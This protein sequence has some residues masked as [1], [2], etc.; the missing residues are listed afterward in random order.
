MATA[1]GIAFLLVYVL[2]A[3]AYGS[4][5]VLS[6]R[7]ASPVW[8]PHRQHGPTIRPRLDLASTA[9]FLWS[10][11]WFVVLAF[12]QFD[13]FLSGPRR[14]VLD[15]AQLVL[16]FGF[17]PLIVH[18]MY[19]EAHVPEWTGRAR[20]WGHGVLIG[21]YLAT[22]LA[23][24]AALALAFGFV[25]VPGAGGWI[26][27]TLAALFTTAGVYSA[28]VMNRNPRA[29][30]TH[31]HRQMR[32]V[33]N[34]LFA[35]L[36]GLNLVLVF[37]GSATP[38]FALIN[39]IMSVTPLLFLS[40]TTYYENRFEFYDLVVKRGALLIA[41]LLVLGAAFALL[42]P[43]LDGLP[44]GP[45][46][47]W[48]YALTLVP[49][50]L[51]TPWLAA[52]LGER[53]DRAWFGRHYTPVSAVTAVLAAIQGAADEPSLL[54]AA[55]AS[56]T[57][58]LGVTVRLTTTPPPP[59]P[60]T[61]VAFEVEGTPADPSMWVSVPAVQ[62][63]RVLLSEDL[64]LLRSL[65]SVVT[66]LLENVRLQQRRQEQDLLAHELRVQS[67]QSELKALR[68]QINPH[69]LFNALN[70]V[71]S[72]I[73]SD[74]ARADRAVEQLSEVFRHTLRRSESEWAPLDQELA[75]AAA[76]LDVEEARFGSRLRYAIEAAPE[77][78]RALVPAMLVHTLVENAVKHGIAQVRGH[79]TL[80]VVARVQ[81][82]RLVVEVADNGPG[83]GA[84]PDRPAQPR[85]V[86]EQF[87]LRSVRDRLRGHF[88]EAAAFTLTRDDARG[89]TVARM[90][91][92]LV[93]PDP[94]RAAAGREVPA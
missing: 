47:P 1:A 2:G 77:A 93:A 17:P 51:I 55:E 15:L 48:L 16:V 44:S 42:L 11:I 69:F 34:G 54:A 32:R 88:G 28:V 70:T 94:K 86:G 84:H 35:V 61:R 76:Y 38:S 90:E 80:D 21:M 89:L 41:A 46:R 71:A 73:H 23:A 79:G 81:G 50:L 9:M 63:E 58:V 92:P 68:A 75:F 66:Y 37:S 3:F 29:V 65:G 78:G 20:A 30:L 60:E 27:G 8:A 10:A 45:S 39:R 25:R 91:L 49:L 59:A 40:A 33:L 82:E 67:S 74:P 57:E 64:R 43:W 53:L 6:L 26:G 18:T 72:L 14:N 83:P 19:L 24:A 31:Q 7:Q 56:L 52:A 87:G 36:I 13:E 5:L 4:A 62:G 85:R 22:P 12:D